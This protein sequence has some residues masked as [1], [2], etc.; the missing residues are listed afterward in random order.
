V[1]G[2]VKPA[3]AT[4]ELWKL[5]GEVLESTGKPYHC[6]GEKLPW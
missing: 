5:M 2:A 4:M 6:S 1:P 3:Q